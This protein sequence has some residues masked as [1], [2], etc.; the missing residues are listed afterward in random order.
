MALNFFLV[1][2]SAAVLWVG[3]ILGLRL[4]V[5]LGDDRRRTR[6]AEAKAEVEDVLLAVEIAR[7]AS[8][9]A[10]GVQEQVRR[11]DN[12]VM[13]EA[14]MDP[15]VRAKRN[16]TSKNEAVQSAG[17]LLKVLDV[18]RVGPRFSWLAHPDN[19]KSFVEEAVA[20]MN[21]KSGG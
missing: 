18:E 13:G 16:E 19:I 21:Q 8:G 15:N 14:G 11:L 1:S 4:L 3:A 17:C 7:M 10:V 9:V 5:G 20:R 12:A 2:C 6:R